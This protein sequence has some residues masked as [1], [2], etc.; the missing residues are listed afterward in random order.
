MTKNFLLLLTLVCTSQFIVA[1]NFITQWNL[2]T[3][4]SGTTQL[5]FGV[6]TVGVV[7]YTWAT[8]PAA[9]SGS[10]TFTGSTATITGLPAGATIRLSIAPTNFRRFNMNNGTDRSRLTL[11]EQWGTTSW[12]SMAT[13]F[14]GCNNLQVSATDIPNLS[15]VTSLSSMFANC[16]VLNSPTN[17]GTWNTTTITD[18]SAVFNGASAFNQPIGA[19]NTGAVTTMLNLFKA[20]S[21]FNQPL[22]SWNTGSVENMMFTFQNTVLFN[23]PIG[24]WNTGSVLYMNGMFGGAQA[25]NQSINSWNTQSVASM[26][27]MFANSA[28]FNQ[29]LASW[30]TSS[31]E[32]M[33]SMFA[34]AQAFNQPIGSWNTGSVVYMSEMFQNAMVFN[35]PVD[36]WNTS[37][38]VDMSYMFD[39]SDVFNQSLD[40]WDISSVFNLSFMFRQAINFNQ[41]LNNWNTSS[42]TNMTQMF[43]QAYNFNQSLASWKLHPNVN[44]NNMLDA[45]G[46]SCSNYSATLMGWRNNPITPTGRNFGAIF[47]TFGSVASAARSQLILAVGAGGKGWTITD[48]GLASSSST[49]SA[50]SSTPT[51]CMYSALPI[52]T[53]STSG[54]SGIGSVSNLPLGVSA[55]YSANT[56]TISGTPTTFGVFQYYISLLGTCNVATGTITV[57]QVKTASSASS[58][59]TLCTNT[60]LANITHTTTIAT[61]I[62]IPAGLPPGVTASWAANTIT[63][64]GAPTSNGTFNYSI[65]LTGGCGTVNATGTI[66]VILGNTFS[67]S[68]NPAV[69]LNAAI[70]NILQTT[71]GAT[72]IGTVSG[73]PAGLVANWVSNTI[74]ISGTPTASGTF[75]YSIPLTGGCGTVSATGTIVVNSNTVGVATASPVVCTNITQLSFAQHATT[76]ATGIGAPSGL[77][78]GIN[79]TWFSNAINISGNPTTPGVY[80]YT[81]PLSGGCGNGNATGIFTVRPNK[82]VSIAS[83]TGTVCVTDLLNPI[84]FTTTNASGIGTPTNLPA[85]LTAVWAADV[86]TISG[87]PTVP[88][89]YNVS[90][91]VS[92]CGPGSATTTINVLPTKTVTVASTTPT[93]CVNTVLTN[94]THSTTVATGIGTPTNLPT[95]VTANWSANTITLSGTPTVSGVFNYSILLTGGC[96]NESATGTIT[97][98]S[99]PNLGVPSSTSSI[100]VN[101][102]MTSFTRAA[103]GVT[104]IGTITGLPA[105][106]NATF[107]LNTLTISGTPTTPGTFNYTVPLTGLCGTSNATGTIVVAPPS[108]VSIANSSPSICFEAAIPTIT[109]TTFGVTGIATVTGLPSGVTATWVSN[110]LSISGTPTVVGSFNYYITFTGTCGSVAAA[111]FMQVN[112]NKTVASASSTPT[113]CIATALS[114]ITH[115]TTVGNGIGAAIGLPTGVIATFA[116]NVI[117]ISGTPTEEGIF[118]Y[119]IPLTGGCGSA[120]ATGTIT[121]TPQ[122]TVSLASASPDL[123][124]NTTLSSITHTTTGATG[125]G[126]STGLP[127]GVIASW[128]ANTITIS[129]TPTVSGV[130]N[131]SIPL[132]GGCGAVNAA[133]T[134]TVSPNNTVSVASST[135]N[136][137]FNS[138]LTTITHITAGATGIGSANGLPAGIS[139]S[140]VANTIIIGGTPT[141]DGIF[142][143]S[144]P[145]TGG[146]GLANATGTITIYPNITSTNTT[147]ICNNESLVINGTTYNAANPSGTEV[148]AN[149]GVNGCDSTVTVNL[150]VLPAL[151]STNTTTICNNESV[152]INGTTYNAANPSGTEVFAN[153]GVNGCD[154]TVTVNLNVLPALTSTN[155]TTICNNENVVINGTNYNAANPT[156]IELFVNIG[157]NGCDSIVTVSLNVLPA[158]NTT[159]SSFDGVFTATTA[160]LAYQWIN[161]GTGNAI[162]SGATSQSFAPT[163][164]G[165]YAV[166]VSNSNCSDTSSCLESNNVGLNDEVLFST[167]SIYPNPSPA[168]VT[169]SSDKE[170]SYELLNAQ[171]KII[172]FEVSAK[173]SHDVNLSEFPI[174]V[175]FVKLQIDESTRIFKVVKM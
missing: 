111:G 172:N 105:G 50:A 140:F 125:I 64:S 110:L 151:T 30:N 103:S 81:I 8:V 130:F 44:L 63:I 173:K 32:V 2:A 117:T 161:C 150:N 112:P 76:G 75:N 142:N 72:G 27:G 94:I 122:N 137:C 60:T 143:Y 158:I 43:F 26:L 114:P 154:S 101:E 166:I 34:G 6:G 79:A 93:L 11:A 144:I 168:F 96:G 118:N 69:C 83:S 65:P 107:A 22:G 129:G 39:G 132:S 148:F 42:A 88:G 82:T 23:Q 7:N 120:N 149:V 71:S 74:T 157:V 19:W 31:V 66:T 67:A 68:T 21:S 170:V 18:M 113:I 28:A 115:S 106:V 162:V 135:Q 57:Q 15:I 48:G 47:K 167:V 12:S 124:I 138:A 20:A 10:G 77:P 155:T 160:G 141:V 24:T 163:A 169:I 119:S 5:T 134:I 128:S 98:T 9:T 52:I 100:C 40:Q 14:N 91:P 90:I 16:S 58:S 175:Y 165:F 92:G 146:C 62:G 61:G 84:T 4:G 59:P 3:A 38:V 139:A 13:A 45:C 126:T 159:I 131:Y 97:V 25:F 121:V 147:T 87:T 80:N 133:G 73:L 29:P 104:S 108:I 70:T 99:N 109:H 171:G 53:H 54:V 33:I 49:V 164:N 89:T 116:S 46:I 37:S 41:D 127:A 51:I 174:G 17:I 56:I 85:G 35:Q 36:T 95:G 156:G 136:I 1:Q 153:V 55:V 123:C 78:P 145:L 152:V 86:I 102:V